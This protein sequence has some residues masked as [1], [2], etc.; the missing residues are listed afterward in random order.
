MNK[1]EFLNQLCLQLNGLP[2]ADI[3]ERLNF[4][5]EMIDDRIEDGLSEEEA[6]CGI[7]SVDE[8]V[9]QILSEIP[10]T[11]LVKERIKTKRRLKAWEIVCLVLGSPVWLSLLISAAAVVISVYAVLW[12]VIICLWAAEVS[13]WGC[14]FGGIV[15]GTAVALFQNVPSGV[16]LIGCGLICAGLSIF[17][18][19][20]CKA[21]TKGALWLTKKIAIGIKNCFIKK[22]NA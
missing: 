7:G 12:S 8:I 17:W 19:F 10:L 4:Y 3:E 16:L 18:F 2:Q 15:S 9:A 13:L 1:N 6:V 22:E 5:S 11:K 20:G 14:A 21:A